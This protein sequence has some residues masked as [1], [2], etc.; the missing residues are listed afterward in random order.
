MKSRMPQLISF[1]SDFKPFFSS[2]KMAQFLRVDQY[3][4]IKNRAPAQITKE[5][6]KLVKEATTYPTSMETNV[7]KLTFNIEGEMS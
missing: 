3:T 4:I 5:T 6:G 2:F 1:A 7:A